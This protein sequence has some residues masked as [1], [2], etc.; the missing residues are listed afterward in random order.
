MLTFSLHQSNPAL[1]SAYPKACFI[2]CIGD[3]GNRWK[4]AGLFCIMFAAATIELFA[5]F[6]NIDYAVSE[7]RNRKY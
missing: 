1:L 6:D 7:K 4:Q 3:V 2:L 5:A